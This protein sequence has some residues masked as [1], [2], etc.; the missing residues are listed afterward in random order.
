MKTK[1]TVSKLLFAMLLMAGFLGL[2]GKAFAYCAPSDPQCNGSGGM[3]DA[4]SEQQKQQITADLPPESKGSYSNGK[5]YSNPEPTAGSVITMP[6][7]MAVKTQKIIGLIG[8]VT[9]EMAE[10]MGSGVGASSSDSGTKIAGS[11]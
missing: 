10:S 4:I 9:A 6:T 7:L 8:A 1:T 11:S 2:S 5:Y 3:N